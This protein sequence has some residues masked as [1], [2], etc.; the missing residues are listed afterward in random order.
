ML[1]DR[2]VERW[3]DAQHTVYDLGC[4]RGVQT[5]R[6]RA[7]E[8]GIERWRSPGVIV[9]DTMQNAG[10]DPSSWRNH[11]WSLLASRGWA[12]RLESRACA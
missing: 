8:L 4:Q 10:G 3:Q 1:F 9:H 12:R 5:A 11:E 6:L 7:S 2:C